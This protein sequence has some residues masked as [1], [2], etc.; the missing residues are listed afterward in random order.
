MLQLT[1]FIFKTRKF[2]VRG[3]TSIPAS[4]LEHVK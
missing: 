2:A 1:I 4:E 3:T